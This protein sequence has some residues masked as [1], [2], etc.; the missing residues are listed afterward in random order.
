MF[1][2]PAAFHLVLIKPLSANPLHRISSGYEGKKG[3]ISTNFSSFFS[4]PF[5]YLPIDVP[6]SKANLKPSLWRAITVSK[7]DCQRDSTITRH[8]SNFA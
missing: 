4:S 5:I 3:Y 6:R 7:F 8:L 1:A 2:L